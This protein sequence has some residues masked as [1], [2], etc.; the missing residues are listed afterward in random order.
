MIQNVAWHEREKDVEIPKRQ[1]KSTGTV[2]RLKQT[3][4]MQSTQHVRS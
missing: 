3:F 4:V 2:Y 1:N